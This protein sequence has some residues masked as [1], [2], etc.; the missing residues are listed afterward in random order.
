M[1][2]NKPEKKD[3]L[4]LRVLF[5]GGITVVCLAVF[6]IPGITLLHVCSGLILFTLMIIGLLGLA[7]KAFEKAGG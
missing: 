6:W 5:W 2:Y 7:E 4:A 3:S 1:P